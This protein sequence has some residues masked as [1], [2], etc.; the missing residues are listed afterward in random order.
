M[1]CATA[2]ER[3]IESSS[4]PAKCSPEKSSRTD[5]AMKVLITLT[6]VEPA[7]RLNAALEAAGVTTA[8][9]S[10]MDDLPGEIRKFKPD[11]IVLTGH[12]AD[13]SNLQIVRDQLWLG[14]GV[15]G[16]ADVEDAALRERLRAVG[17]VDVY[18]KPVE[19]EELY[20]AVRRVLDRRRLSE[21]T[22]L[23][24]QSG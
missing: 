16:L 17:F 14:T 13:A 5:E 8:V 18:T 21:I 23:I 22:G 6:D 7:V 15:I 4:T 12:L 2:S 19:P 10:P 1:E 24:G 20:L 9:V 3:W 11:V